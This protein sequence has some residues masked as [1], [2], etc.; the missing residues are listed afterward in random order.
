MLEFWIGALPLA[1]ALDF[2]LG[3]P[4][5]LPHPVRLIGSFITKCENMLRRLGY[6]DLGGGFLLVVFTLVFTISLVTILLAIAYEIHIWVHRAISVWLLYQGLALGDLRKEVL[7][8]KH[9]LLLGDLPLA[10]MRTARIV[11]RST[12][13]MNYTTLSSSTIESAAENGV[14]GVLSPLFWITIGGP[15]GLWIYKASSTLDSM[16][17]YRSKTYEKFGK[18]AARLDDALNWIPARLSLPLYCLTTLPRFCHGMRTGWQDHKLH[19]SPNS[20]WSEATMSGL[21]GI[22]LGGPA[23]YNDILI[24]KPW[25]GAHYHDAQPHDIQRA[26]S[27]V[28]KASLLGLAMSITCHYLPVFLTYICSW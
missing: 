7:S 11:S 25:F 24:P 15:V 5:W 27:I 22:R 19:A 8:I 14:D 4:P 10:R 23:V 21:L 18:T 3:D 9:A 17:G 20:G 16:V 12:A 1:F 13:N 26:I 6:K 28:T 2:L